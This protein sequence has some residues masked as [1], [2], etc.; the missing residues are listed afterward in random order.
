MDF[1]RFTGM[2]L[3]LQKKLAKIKQRGRIPAS[4]QISSYRLFIFFIVL[5]DGG[6]H[7]SL[8]FCGR[9]IAREGLS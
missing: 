1:F 5:F 3:S 2:L 4:L 9:D 6:F 7:L 8:C